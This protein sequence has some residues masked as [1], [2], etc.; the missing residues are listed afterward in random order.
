MN[1]HQ[2]V[3]E[4]DLTHQYCRIAQ[5]DMYAIIRWIFINSVDILQLIL[6][7]VLCTLWVRGTK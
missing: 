7:F 5:L 3:L 4:S 6:K 2:L 1:S